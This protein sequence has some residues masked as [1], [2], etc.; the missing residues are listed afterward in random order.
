MYLR[1]G[2]PITRSSRDDVSY[3]ASSDTVRARD[4]ALGFGQHTPSF[5]EF[6]DPSGSPVHNLLDRV[7]VFRASGFLL[8]DRSRSPSA[9]GCPCPISTGCRPTG[10]G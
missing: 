9:V 2:P 5:F 3:E 1:V 8:R 4:Y 7:K 6:A 10:S